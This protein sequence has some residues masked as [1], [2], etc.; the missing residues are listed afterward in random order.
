MQPS[1]TRLQFNVWHHYTNSHDHVSVSID[2]S[3]TEFPLIC[4]N[5]DFPTVNV[6][7]WS[8]SIASL[9]TYITSDVKLSVAL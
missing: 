6:T 3:V 7:S 9:Y 4:V 5:I 1:Y 2:I 8:V